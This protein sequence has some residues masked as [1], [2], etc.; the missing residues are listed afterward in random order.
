[1]S[2]VVQQATGG[3]VTTPTNGAAESYT[4]T[5]TAATNRVEGKSASSLGLVVYYTLPNGGSETVVTVNVTLKD[6]T[7]YS[8]TLSVQLRTT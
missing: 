1:M 7:G 5:T 8:Y 2:V 3:I 4:Y 6:D